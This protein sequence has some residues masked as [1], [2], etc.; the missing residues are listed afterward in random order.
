MQQAL[1][2]RMAALPSMT[3]AQLRA[4]W[5]RVVGSPSPAAYGKNLLAR[6]IAYHLQA[7]VH[8]GLSSKAARQLRQAQARTA[9][10]L[11]VPPAPRLRQGTM[12]ARDWQGR[13]HH[14]L[15]LEEGYSYQDRRYR[16]LSAIAFEITGARWSGPRFFGLISKPQ[17]RRRDAA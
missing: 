9:Q 1:A 6:G 11:R 4:E 2:T 7:A 5:Q 13:T 14:V 17:E 15:V 16:S 3:A 10:G 12:L 8:G